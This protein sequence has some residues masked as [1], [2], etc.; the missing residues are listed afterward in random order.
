MEYVGA[1]GHAYRGTLHAL[2]EI[3]RAEGLRG[4]YRGIGPTALSQAPFSALYYMFY[5]QLQASSAPP[6][7]GLPRSMLPRS[8]WQ[9]PFGRGLRSASLA[10]K[11]VLSWACALF[12][13]VCCTR[14]AQAGS[15]IPELRCRPP[16]PRLQERLKGGERPSVAVNFVS[17]TLA[18]MAATVLTQPADVI[19]TRMQ[20][21]LSGAAGG[22]G[23]PAAQGSTLQIFRQIVGQQGLRGLLVGAAP[24]VVKRTLQTALLWT[25]YEELYPALSRAGET[26]HAHIAAAAEPPTASPGGG[27]G[28]RRDGGGDRAA[29]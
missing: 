21:D 26:L 24:R 28:G 18:G 8:W 17:G 23:A 14:G 25:L 13:S 27:G 29:A 11:G 12:S 22:A 10:I 2:R 19:R 3:W 16:S 15:N 4:M 5:T 20:L 6:L 7:G 9:S 1:G